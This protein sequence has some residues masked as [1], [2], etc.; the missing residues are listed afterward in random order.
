MTVPTSPGWYPDPEDASQLRYFDGI[1]WSS[2]TTPLQS[3]TAAASTIGRAPQMPSAAERAAQAEQERRPQQPAPYGPAGGWTAP[4]ARMPAPG[5]TLPDGAVLAEWWRRLVARIIDRFLTSLLA[6]VAS[7][8]FLGPLWDAMRTFVD[9]TVAG[10]TPD[11]TALTNAILEVSVPT[12]L[13]SLAVSLVYE[14]GFLTWRSATPGKMLLGTVVRPAEAPG[15]VGFPIA[16]RRQLVGITVSV[17]SLSTVL[18]FAGTFL[19]VLDPAWLLWDRRRQCLH[20]KV[21]G[22]VVVLKPR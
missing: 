10:R 11:Q 12:I 15:P 16:L 4:P 5:S 19:S 21:A 9:D 18:G 14:I 1:V 7:L 22:T 3:P 6:F 20:D 2:H 17:F 8:P 13:V